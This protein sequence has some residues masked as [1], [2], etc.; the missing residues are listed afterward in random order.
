[1]CCC[2]GDSL[3]VQG[4]RKEQFLDKVTGLPCQ[5]HC[6]LVESWRIS[7]GKCYEGH[8]FC[9]ALQSS[10]GLTIPGQ[11]WNSSWMFSQ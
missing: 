4:G 5:P 8:L 9:S 1:M 10:Q 6:L 11:R 3:T 2:R 7:E